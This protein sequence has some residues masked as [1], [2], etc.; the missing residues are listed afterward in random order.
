MTAVSIVIKDISLNFVMLI[1]VTCSLCYEMVTEQNKNCS[2]GPGGNHTK[3]IP[4]Y[5]L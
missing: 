1:G 3:G 4:L 5:L 2:F